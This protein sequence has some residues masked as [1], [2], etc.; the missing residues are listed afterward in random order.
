LTCQ[1]AELVL[2]GMITSLSGCLFCNPRTDEEIKA[3]GLYARKLGLFGMIGALKRR[4]L[5]W[6]RGRWGGGE[7]WWEEDFELFNVATRLIII[8]CHLFYFWIKVS[9]WYLPFQLSKTNIFY[10][11]EFFFG[12]LLL[13]LFFY[14]KQYDIYKCKVLLYHPPY[15]PLRIL[16][17]GYARFERRKN[18]RNAN[19]RKLIVLWCLK[20]LTVSVLASS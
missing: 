14:S 20:L 18:K 11:V 3:K 9:F 12:S 13:I 8:F 16:T 4:R 15:N 5:L 2:S 6:K 10:P 19:E 7:K 1:F 17:V